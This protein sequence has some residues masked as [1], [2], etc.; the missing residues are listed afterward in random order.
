[1]ITA[2]PLLGAGLHAAIATALAVLVGAVIM[3]TYGNF[4]AEHVSAH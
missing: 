4:L 3:L 2:D 1:M